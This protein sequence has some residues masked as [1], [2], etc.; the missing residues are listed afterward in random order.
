MNLLYQNNIASAEQLLALCREKGVT[1]ATAESCTGGMIGATITS[2]PGCSDIY[3]GGI[4]SYANSAKESLLE[5]SHETL[6]AHGAVSA[7]TAEEMAKGAVKALG[8]TLAVSVTGIAGPGGQTHEKPVGLVH[9]GVATKDRVFT[10]KR[11]FSGS[12]ES[13]RLKAVA[14]AIA[15]LE[16]TVRTL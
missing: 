4:V 8:A 3:L 6:K 15:L 9:F 13:I 7:E 5:V 16:E 1:L 14:A 10:D 2:V 12:R 11:N